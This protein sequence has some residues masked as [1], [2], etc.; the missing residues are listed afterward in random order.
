MYGDVMEHPTE[1]LIFVT[2]FI[3]EESDGILLK[4]THIASL[5]L[6]KSDSYR[7]VKPT[8]DLE[9]NLVAKTKSKI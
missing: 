7:L 6:Q 3:D 5:P 9:S 4:S 1:Y 2:C 8:S